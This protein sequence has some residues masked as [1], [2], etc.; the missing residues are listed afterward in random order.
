MKN[1]Y[2]DCFGKFK[3]IA[4]KCPDSCCAGWDVVVDDETYELYKELD[5]SLGEKIR[6]AMTVDRDGDR[7]FVLKNGRCPFFNRDNLCDII[8]EKGDNCLCR[9]CREFPRIR[10]DYTAFCEH[11]L[12]FA[13]PEAAGLMLESEN[14]YEKF[15][16]Y[17]LC[18]DGYGYNAEF[19]EF[20]LDVRSKSVE[21]LRDKSL[22]FSSRLKKC[23]EFNK[24]VQNKIDSF[25]ED[26]TAGE[27]LPENDICR[28]VAYI[29][30]FFKSLDIMTD[31]WAKMLQNVN[32]R[33]EKPKID[34]F[35]EYFEKIALYYVYRYYLNAIDSQNVLN[36]IKKIA[37]ACIVISCVCEDKSDFVQV[38]CLYSKEVEHSYEN[39]EA[40]ESEFYENKAF[41][42]KNLLKL[43]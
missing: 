39:E 20:L 19:M 37:C 31:K 23:L 5:G 21:I 15:G 30:E 40:L 6:E 28:D 32:L 1:I 13:C 17:E 14:N 18:F 11:M 34:R 43:I 22:S 27:K 4:D 8:I 41:S 2:S 10:Q 12:S 24:E 16:R 3:C 38:A 42:V 29:I 7:I 9:T 36:T 25:Y 33:G 26:D 35:G